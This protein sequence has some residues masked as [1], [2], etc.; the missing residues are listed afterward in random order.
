MKP[1]DEQ[2]LEY[3]LGSFGI[4]SCMMNSEHRW[5]YKGRPLI[6]PSIRE[7]FERCYEKDHPEEMWQSG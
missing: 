3:I 4:M 7:A 1:T 2:L 6:G 5:S